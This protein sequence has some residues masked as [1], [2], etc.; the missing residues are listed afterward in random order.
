ML[1]ATLWAA[2]YVLSCSD[3]EL[4]RAGTALDSVFGHCSVL[5]LGTKQ[6]IQV[7]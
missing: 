2:E 6:L 5:L 7:R 3:I 4:V 1:C